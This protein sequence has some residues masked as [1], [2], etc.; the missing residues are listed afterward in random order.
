MKRFD[1]TVVTSALEVLGVELTAGYGVT[2]D[3]SR[4]WKS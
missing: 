2:L 1:V 4:I 3:E